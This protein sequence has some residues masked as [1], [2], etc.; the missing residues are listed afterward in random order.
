ML[1]MGTIRAPYAR[2]SRTLN[3]IFG[4]I[5]TVYGLYLLLFM[6]SGHYIIFFYAFVLPILMAVRFFRAR[7]ASG[8]A[9]GAG[10]LPPNGYGQPAGYGQPGQPAPY[11]QPAGYGQ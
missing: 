5:F 8:P 10:Q 9:R 3:F 1:A 2:S 7:A 6:E 11:G 4:G